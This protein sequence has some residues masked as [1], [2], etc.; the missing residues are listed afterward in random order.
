MAENAVRWFEIYVQDMARATAFYEK[1]LGCKLDK[2][3]GV[4]LREVQQVTQQPVHVLCFLADHMADA[5]GVLLGRGAVPQR[6]CIA[7]DRGHRCLQ[8]M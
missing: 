2:L 6:L 3:P 4:D 8:I 5:L 7:R 1:V